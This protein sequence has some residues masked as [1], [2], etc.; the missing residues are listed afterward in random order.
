MSAPLRDHD[1]TFWVDVDHVDG[2]AV[3]KLH[4]DL[5]IGGTELLANAVR[6]VRAKG[7]PTVILDLSTL[8][9]VDSS[10]LREFLLALRAQREI[11][12]DVVLSGPTRSTLRLLE[13]VGMTQ[14]FTIA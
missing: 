9:F 10:G 3:L 12:G 14:I 6:E 7:I 11:G 8:A 1:E 5:D 4:G 13:I 2:H